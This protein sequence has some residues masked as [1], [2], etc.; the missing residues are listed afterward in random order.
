M[1]AF[2]EDVRP[3]DL[4]LDGGA[5]WGLYS[6][7]ASSRGARVWA[8]EPSDENADRLEYNLRVVRARRVMVDRRALADRTGAIAFYTYEGPEWGRTM[9]A[10]LLAQPFT[11][12]VEVPC[13]TIDALAVQPAVIK[14]DVEGA[15]GLVLEGAR[16]TLAAV[17]PILYIEAHLDRMQAFNTTKAALV[18]FLQNFGYDVHILRSE[19]ILHGRESAEYWRCNPVA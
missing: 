9:M 3:G 7:L 4:V 10:G 12:P 8:F 1:A 13:T 16:D 6:V 19:P 15:E 18:A 17:R 5:H 14:L 2:Q 11:R